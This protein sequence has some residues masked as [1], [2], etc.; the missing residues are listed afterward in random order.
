MLVMLMKTALQQATSAIKSRVWLLIVVVLLSHTST[1]AAQQEEYFLNDPSAKKYAMILVGTSFDLEHEQQ[2]ALWA[3]TLYDALVKDLHYDPDNLFLL[4]GNKPKDYQG[5]ATLGACRLENL[6]N[7]FN[8]L[9][10]IIQ[11][12]DQLTVF[13]FGHGS[14][15]DDE[16]KFNI[17][18]PDITG[19]EFATFLNALKVNNMVVI[20][21]TSASHDFSQA[22]SAPG[23]VVISATRSRA[24]K[25]DTRF[26]GYV[27]EAIRQ[28]SGDRDKN[29]RLS[30]LETFL[31][32]KNRVDSFYADGGTLSTEHS[33]VDDNGDGIFS[34]EANFAQGDGRLAEIAYL[35]ADLADAGQLSAAASEL[36]I[37]MDNLE[38][39]VFLLRGQKDTMTEQQYWQQMEPLL[40][41]LSKVSKAF[42]ETQ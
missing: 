27:V 31:F 40:I 20:D 33:S 41:D 35:D 42:R 36:K 8:K 25:Y 12:H 30:A 17:V 11:P 29:Q 32:A 1:V 13:L 23:R 10:A 39:S 16:A 15:F 26:P 34:M 14:G 5:V 37:K 6:R 19:R 28:H 18:G 24:E 2:F 7:I 3:T 21:T 4:L 9:A 22:L 38:R